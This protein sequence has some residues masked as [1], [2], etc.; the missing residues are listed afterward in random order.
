VCYVI[1]TFLVLSPGFEE[2]SCVGEEQ[3]LQ[4]HQN[5]SCRLSLP[6]LIVDLWWFSFGCLVRMFFR[7]YH[8]Y[9]LH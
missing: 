7:V 9:T 5:S 8:A 6:L 3:E 1:D 4:G 2:G